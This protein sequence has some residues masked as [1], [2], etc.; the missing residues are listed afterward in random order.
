MDSFPLA[1]LFVFPAFLIFCRLGMALLVF[2]AISDPSIP[3]RLRLLIAVGTTLL[4]LPLLQSQLPT[5]PAKT[6]V[7]VSLVGAELMVGLLMGIVARWMM[8]AFAI[9]GEQIAFMSGFQA[10]TLFDPTS[11]SSSAAPTVFM[12]LTASAFILAIGLHHQLIEGIMHSYQV[13]PAG[14]WPAIGG[15]LQALI[16]LISQVFLL[17]LQLSAPVVVAGFLGYVVFG[18][19]NRLIPQLQVFFVSLPVSL[20]LSMLILAASLGG[21]LSLFASQLQAKLFITDYGTEDS[22]GF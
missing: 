12:S 9:A 2:P 22:D 13:F 16:D 11:G 7:M 5:L 17:G 1:S 19:F 10:A 4:F 6:G 3:T 15:T 8:A 14:Q 21:M 18:I 20:T